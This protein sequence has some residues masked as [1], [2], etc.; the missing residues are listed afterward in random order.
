MR[1]A[2]SSLASIVLCFIAYLLIGALPAGYVSA[3]PIN[4]LESISGDLPTGLP[5][6]PVFSLDLGANRISGSISYTFQ[7]PQCPE[8]PAPADVD[9]FAFSV[10][11]GTELVS[12][13]FRFATAATTNISAAGAFYR[14]CPDNIGGSISCG[15]LY[16]D[17]Q[18]FALLGSSPVSAFDIALPLGP[19]TYSVWNNSL[20]MTTFPGSVSPTNP[21]SWSADY[22]WMLRVTPTRSV[23]EP[24]TLALLCVALAGLGFARRRKL[25]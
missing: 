24:G 21:A 4:Y 13:S 2:R 9:P 19:G 16:L 3:A 11:A 7:G 14:L 15:G 12:V 8:C 18:D 1:T 10:P 5:A 17:S 22:T 6:S 23:P 25:H 20:S